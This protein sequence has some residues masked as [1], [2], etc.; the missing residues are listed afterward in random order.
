MKHSI[1][2]AT[3]LI[4]ALG[5]ACGGGGEESDTAAGIEDAEPIPDP[6]DFCGEFTEAVC[7]KAMTCYTAEERAQ[8]GMA[9]SFEDCLAEIDAR[10]QP[11]NVCEDGTTYDPDNA[12]ACVV[13]FEAMTCEAIRDPNVQPGPACSAI[14]Q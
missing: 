13:E 6:L 11:D 4:L 7:N 5:C 12:G 9:A 8:Y 1:L 14:C 3:L 10:C 2:R